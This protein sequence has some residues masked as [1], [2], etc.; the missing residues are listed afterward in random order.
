MARAGNAGGDSVHSEIEYVARRPLFFPVFDDRVSPHLHALALPF[1]FQRGCRAIV[2]INRQMMPQSFADNPDEDANSITIHASCSC[3]G[4]D[5]I[6][7]VRF[8]GRKPLRGRRLFVKR[9]EPGEPSEV[10]RPD[11][12]VRLVL[13]SLP[14]RLPCKHQVPSAERGAAAVQLS[15]F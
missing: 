15:G 9:S 10:I 2:V 5:E 6:P 3:C 1:S 8:A 11:V 7:E 14:S 13:Q 4:G 12:P